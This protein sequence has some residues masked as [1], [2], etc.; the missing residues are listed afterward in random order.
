[1]AVSMEAPAK[2]RGSKHDSGKK[3]VYL[4]DEVALAE[5]AVGGAWDNVKALLGGKGAG[6]A[7]YD[8]RRS[9]RPTRL[10]HHDRSLQLLQ[11]ERTGFPRR[12][13]GSGS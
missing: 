6:L 8:P 10:Q 11:Q 5:K 12:H 3:W 13:V 1:M 7:R 9:A 4:F 2:K